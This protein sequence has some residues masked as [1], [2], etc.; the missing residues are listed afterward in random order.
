LKYVK[1]AVKILI[2]AII[3]YFIF[4][5]LI[6]NWSQLGTLNFKANYVYGVFSLIAVMAAWF[7]TAWNWGRVL[8]AFHSEISFGDVFNI[9]FKTNL[10]KY[11]PG[12]VW[13]IAGSTYM[14]AQRGIPEGMALTVSLAAQAYS[15]LSGLSLFAAAMA[16]GFVGSPG[17]LHSFFKV[18]A[19][20]V[21]IT[22][23]VLAA[24]PRLVEP[25]VNWWMRLF[26]RQEVTIHISLLNA[27]ELFGLYLITWFL[28]GLGLWFLA[29]A[30]TPAG[31]GIYI[32]LTVVLAIAVV[33]GFLALFAPG[34]LGVREGIMVL[35]LTPIPALPPPVPSAI[36]VG[37]RIISMIVE[38]IAF[39]LT[40]VIKWN[41]KN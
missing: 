15:V 17:D 36:A 1:N 5:N 29:N 31:F 24:R 38:T 12:K 34:G 20:P 8:R 13:Q 19:I 35:F 33:I 28:F 18:S 21:L 39:G 16:F 41:S 40:W 2:V 26:R 10:G 27:A 22:L 30:L 7:M 11:L 25:I 6:S 32:N 4:R 37:F 9:Y 23:M 3:F 14:A